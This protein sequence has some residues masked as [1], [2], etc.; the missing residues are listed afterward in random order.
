MRVAG[1]GSLGGAAAV[2]AWLNRRDLVLFAWDAP[3]DTEALIEA[4]S[5]REP[6]WQA[7]LVARLVL[8]ISGE[9]SPGAP[10]VMTLLRRTGVPRRSTTRSWS[11]GSG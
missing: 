10:L 2:A 11:P 7:D 6:Q 1:A 3:G 9:D 5:A 8:R 4:I